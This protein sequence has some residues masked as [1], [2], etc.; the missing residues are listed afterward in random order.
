MVS[1]H[2]TKKKKKDRNS[3]KGLINLLRGS[4]AGKLL[5]QE[6]SQNNNSNK[7]TRRVT[8][9]EGTERDRDPFGYAF[10]YNSSARF[11]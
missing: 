5:G 2:K 10:L 9:N 8:V 11:P 3:A 1:I 6:N 7:N 4:T